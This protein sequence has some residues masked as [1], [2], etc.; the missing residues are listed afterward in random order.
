MPGIVKQVLTLFDGIVSHILWPAGGFLFDFQEGVDVVSEDGSALS[1]EMPSFVHFQDLVSLLAA[2]SSSGEH[3][4][5]VR[6][7]SSEV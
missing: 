3:Q 6:A 5:P 4:V 1:W 7:R 2:S